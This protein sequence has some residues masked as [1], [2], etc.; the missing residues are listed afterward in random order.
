MV[1]PMSSVPSTPMPARSPGARL[2]VRSR[3]ETR[4]PART[5]ALP[6]RGRPAR[7]D[8][9]DVGRAARDRRRPDPRRAPRGCLLA[10]PARPRWSVPDA[11]R[12]ERPRPLPDR[13][14]A[15]PVRRGR[16]RPASPP[17]ADRWSSPTSRPTPASCGSAASTSAGS[18]PRCCR[19]P[20]TW[21]DQIVGVLNVQT[22]QRADVQR[23]TTSPSSAPSPTCSPGS[24]R[25]AASSPRPRRGSRRSR[26]STR[27]AAS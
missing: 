17:S 22:E 11:G 23:R 27:R 1:M 14:G 15:R 9:A 25:R 12:D 10:L 4:R 21:H 6:A 7:D 8:R 24:S 26:P 13:P 16:D 3:P 5:A 20:L 2:D 18:S 19:V